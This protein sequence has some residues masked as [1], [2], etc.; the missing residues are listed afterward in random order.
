MPA[1]VFCKE[2]SQPERSAFLLQWIVTLDSFL[3]V[4]SDRARGAE[5]FWH[6]VLRIIFT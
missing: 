2:S 6:T 4:R 3:A 5:S 1:G